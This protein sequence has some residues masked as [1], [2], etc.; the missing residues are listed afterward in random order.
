M[1]KYRAKDGT[2]IGV[3]PEPKTPPPPP[4]APD[5]SGPLYKALRTLEITSGKKT[6]D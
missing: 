5:R 2:Y 6:K 1:S 3:G 4:P